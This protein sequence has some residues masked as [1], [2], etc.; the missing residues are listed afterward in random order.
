MKN[1]GIQGEIG[2]IVL[3]IRWMGKTRE[4][5]N[6]KIKSRG[7]NLYFGYVILKCLFV[8]QIQVFIEYT[9]SFRVSLPMLILLLQSKQVI[10]FY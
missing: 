5:K 7:S 4:L 8:L 2:N 3:A 6:I 1:R 10:Y 9:V